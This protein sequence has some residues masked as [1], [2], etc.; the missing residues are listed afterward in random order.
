MTTD[1]LGHK[2]H[3]LQLLSCSKAYKCDLAA[4]PSRGHCRDK[5]KDMLRQQPR[6]G[7]SQM[8]HLPSGTALPG[9]PERCAGTGRHQSAPS[10]AALQRSCVGCQCCSPPGPSPACSCTIASVNIHPCTHKEHVR[11]L[12]TA[13][14]KKCNAFT[15]DASTSTCQ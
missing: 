3:T 14:S 15:K 12:M 6:R 10:P 5:I 9:S 13:G 4:H 11:F 8:A 1:Q 7:L 2:A